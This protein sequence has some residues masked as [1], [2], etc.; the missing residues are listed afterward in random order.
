M[1][2]RATTEHSSEA[3]HDALQ[4]SQGR[5]APTR[6]CSGRVQYAQQKTQEA[7]GCVLSAQLQPR[8][9][10]ALPT[11]IPPTRAIKPACLQHALSRS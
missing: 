9:L 7:G 1:A 4:Q 10:S 3:V 11:G 6:C 5:E 8:P 2:S